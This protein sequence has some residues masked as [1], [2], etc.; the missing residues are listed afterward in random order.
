MYYLLSSEFLNK[1]KGNILCSNQFVK[2]SFICQK[3]HPH[4]YIVPPTDFGAK[5]E[6]AH[7]SMSCETHFDAPKG[8]RCDV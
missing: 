2:R 6:S 4:A 1:R 5:A 8:W 3:F 7:Q